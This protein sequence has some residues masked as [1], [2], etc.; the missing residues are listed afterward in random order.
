MSVKALEAVYPSLP[1]ET[2]QALDKAF[3][4]DCKG[5]D[6]TFLNM[7]ISPV[8]GDP[9][10]ANVTVRTIYT[11]QPKTGQTPPSE[12]VSDFFQLRKVGDEWSIDN[13]G[14]MDSKRIR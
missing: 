13:R 3:K 10:Q 14:M 1:R 6:V 7:Q 4:R 2:K 8:L 5:F 11:C 9:N 12:P